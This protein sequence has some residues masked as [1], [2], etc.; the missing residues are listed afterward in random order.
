MDENI[1]KMIE[2]E[3]SEV[4]DLVAKGKNKLQ[5]VLTDDY[6]FLD[7]DGLLE[8]YHTLSRISYKLP[9]IQRYWCAFKDS[10]KQSDM[11]NQDL[12]ININKMDEIGN[13][14]TAK[15]E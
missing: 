13:L 5:V 8:V 3:S 14:H 4:A 12:Q 15:G 6:F 9:T 2:E 7:K 1:G 11:L 10:A